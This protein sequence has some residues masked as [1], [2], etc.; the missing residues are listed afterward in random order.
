MSDHPCIISVA[1]TGA[2]TRKDQTPYLP[3][4][5]EEIAT[6]AIESWREGAAIAHI[7][8]RKPDGSHTHDLEL[9]KE[10]AGRIRAESDLIL[11]FTTSYFP[12]MTEVQR[13]EVVTL[14]PE[15]A[16]FN[17][18]SLNFADFFVYENSP[19]FM[20]RMAETM[21]DYGVKP[22]FEVFDTGQLGNIV[23]LIDQGLF[24]P[25][26]LFQFVTG[27]KGAMPSDARL[28]RLAVDMLPPESE[29]LAI[30]VGKTQIEMNALAILWGGHPRT[31]FEDNI[32]YRRGE[33]ATSNAQLVARL[34]RLANEL[35]RGVATPARARQLLRLRDAGAP[36]PAVR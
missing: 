7:H 1:I 19:Q 35:E 5:P 12:G 2:V 13:F 15:M 30:G 11:N 10:I 16:S 25:P 23:R 36:P 27:P 14:Q 29:W 9:Y 3:C 33:L 24:E 32:Y 4:T 6:S 22:E 34:A 17:S 31:G 21:R 18:G 20:L 8:V 28:L 26:Y